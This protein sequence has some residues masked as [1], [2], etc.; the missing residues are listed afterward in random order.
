[1]VKQG[2]MFKVSERI[3]SI[4][5]KK[6]LYHNINSYVFMTMKYLARRRYGPKVIYRAGGNFVR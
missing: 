3:A 1:M 4:I 2:D 6:T 5:R